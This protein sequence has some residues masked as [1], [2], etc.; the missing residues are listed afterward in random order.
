METGLSLASNGRLGGLQRDS[1]GYQRGRSLN[2]LA[3]ARALGQRSHSVRASRVREA[4]RSEAD[5]GQQ[6]TGQSPTF[7]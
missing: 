3:N 1:A 7:V 2:F 6:A 4:C 5:P